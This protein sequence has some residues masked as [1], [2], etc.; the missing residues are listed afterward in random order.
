MRFLLGYPPGVRVLKADVSE[1]SVGSIF[2]GRSMK[3][4]RDWSVRDIYT[5]PGS[6]TRTPG[7]YPKEN[8]LHIKHG[9]SLKSRIILWFYITSTS[10]ISYLNDFAF[11]S[12]TVVRLWH[13]PPEDGQLWP[14]NVAVNVVICADF[15]IIWLLLKQKGI[16]KLNI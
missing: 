3:C 6:G 16:Y 4:D 11:T 15:S 8:A 12:C 1:L 13:G 2:I 10:C 9:E 7:R 14:K 5:G